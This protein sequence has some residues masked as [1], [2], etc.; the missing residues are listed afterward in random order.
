MQHVFQWWVYLHKYEGKIPWTSIISKTSHCRFTGCGVNRRN[1]H[2]LAAPCE[3]WPAFKGT[4][5]NFAVAIV[6]ATSVSYGASKEANFLDFRIK[7]T[8]Q[9]STGEVKWSSDSR[10]KQCRARIFSHNYSGG[11][12]I[13]FDQ[14][15]S[16][17]R[18]KVWWFLFN[19]CLVGIKL[20][21][22]A[23]TRPLILSQLCKINSFTC[24]Q[25]RFC[26]TELQS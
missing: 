7:K 1:L 12:R 11:V 25:F 20:F 24:I 17:Y 26:K 10:R 2:L 22:N 15:R 18:K 9:V 13:D 14:T 4:F 19:L 5:K 6:T 16:D 3:I 8:W 23:L 21:Y